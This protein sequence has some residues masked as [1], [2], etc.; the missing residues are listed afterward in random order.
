MP[1]RVDSCPKCGYTTDRDVAAAQIV[2][3]RGAVAV[4]H[5]V[6][7][8]GG[9]GRRRSPIP[10]KEESEGLS[11]GETPR[12][13]TPRNGFSV[14]QPWECQF[15]RLGEKSKGKGERLLMF[16]LALSL[17][18]G[19]LGPGGELFPEPFPSPY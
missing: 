13:Y 8:S 3:Q 5:T 4:G 18:R 14:A 15:M 16:F 7:A 19:Y 10:V 9:I 2:V 1:E 6:Q 11:P 17:S 12:V